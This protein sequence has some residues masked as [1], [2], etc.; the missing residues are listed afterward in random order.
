MTAKQVRA[1]HTREF[2][3]EAVRK[4]RAGQA[5][6][7]AAKVLGISKASLGNLVRSAAKGELGGAGA[8]D[9]RARESPEQMELVS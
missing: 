7:V 2:K 3:L 4:V 5:I 9:K 6:A 1:Q 8:D